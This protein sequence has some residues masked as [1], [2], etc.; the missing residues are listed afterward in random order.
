MEEKVYFIFDCVHIGWNKKNRLIKYSKKSNQVIITP[1]VGGMTIEG[2]N[3]AY[4]HALNLLI[5][6]DKKIRN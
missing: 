5:N 4:N 6:Y 3:I 1:H 2:Q